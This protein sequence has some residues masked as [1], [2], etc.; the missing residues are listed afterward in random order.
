MN[1]R[2]P[3]L[4]HIV[5]AGGQNFFGQLGNNSTNSSAVPVQVAGSS[6]FAAIAGAF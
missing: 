4:T 3:C 5:R 1:S 2:L 6:T